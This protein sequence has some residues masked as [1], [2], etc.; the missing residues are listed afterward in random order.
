MI[1]RVW[2]GRTTTENAEPYLAHLRGETLPGLRGLDGYAG[3]YV[4]RR[5]AD[6]GVDFIVITLWMSTGSIR[7]FA[8]DDHES[9]VIPEEA[10][11]LL[12]AFDDRADHYTV[13]IEDR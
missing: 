3:G 13:A 9:A 5:D 12:A 8:G 1:A 6:L 11:R 4:L 2:R 10:Q 7:A